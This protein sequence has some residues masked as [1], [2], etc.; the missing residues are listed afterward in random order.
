[1]GFKLYSDS[2]MDRPILMCDVCGG[3]L[4]DL[5]ADKAS[6]SPGSNGQITDVVVHHAKCASAGAVHIPLLDFLK[7]FAIENRIGTL[8]T[9]GAVNRLTVEHPAGKGFEE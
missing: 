8:G 7:L 3:Q 5:F 4:V 1:M 6:G 2:M 9:D